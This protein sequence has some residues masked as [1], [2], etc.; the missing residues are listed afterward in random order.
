MPVVRLLGLVVLL[1]VL[2]LLVLSDMSDGVDLR[3]IRVRQGGEL[4]DCSLQSSLDASKF[5]SSSIDLLIGSSG[6]IGV[7]AS[8]EFR[9]KVNFL[10]V[11]PKGVAAAALDEGFNRSM[12]FFSSSMIGSFWVDCACFFIFSFR[13]VRPRSRRT[14]RRNRLIRGWVTEHSLFFFF[15][16]VESVTESDSEDESE[17]Q[18]SERFFFLCFFCSNISMSVNRL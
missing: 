6:S 9:G 11:L 8:S 15:L 7:D 16:G 5:F 4:F 12:V 17:S 2:L 3:L 14:M 1:L 18:G 10:P 13:Q